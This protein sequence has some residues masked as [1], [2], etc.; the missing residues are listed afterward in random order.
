MDSIEIKVA[1]NGFVLCYRDPEIVKKNANSDSWTDPYRQRVYNSPEALGADLSKLLPIMK[2]YGE[3]KD[4]A[5]EYS[6]ALSE[7]FG[8]K[9]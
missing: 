9:T 1:D 3:E 6:L 2:E 5:S 7:A 8:D 4:D